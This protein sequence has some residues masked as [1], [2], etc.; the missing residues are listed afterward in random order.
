MSIYIAQP[1]NEAQ[2]KAIKAVLDA[3]GI[4]YKTEPAVPAYNSEFEEKM[5]RG[6]EDKKSGHY[7]IIKTDDLWK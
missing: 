6:E 4:P 3:L 5:R 2:D 1:Q 7:K